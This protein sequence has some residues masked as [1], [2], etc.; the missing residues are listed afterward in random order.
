MTWTEDYDTALAIAREQGLPILVAIHHESQPVCRQL[1]KE[2]YRDREIV[3]LSRGLVMLLADASA[4]DGAGDDG[5]FGGVSAR[6]RQDIEMRVRQAILNEESPIAPQHVFLSSAGELILQKEYMLSV[7]ELER[8]MQQAIKIEA[9]SGGG[10]GADPASIQSALTRYREADNDALRA[11]VVRE[12][13]DAGSNAAVEA[14]LD[15]TQRQSRARTE[16][17]R[18]LA[19]A[20]GESEHADATPHLAKLLKHRTWQVREG[21]ARGL[22]TLADSGAMDLIRERLGRERQPMVKGRLLEAAATCGT[23]DPDTA[24]LILAHTRK[25]PTSVRIDAIVA[26]HHFHGDVRAT[27]RLLEILEDGPNENLRAAAAWSLA[28]FE[29]PG[30]AEAL[31]EAAEK[32]RRGRHAEVFASAARYHA[33]DPDAGDGFEDALGT[34]RQ[35]R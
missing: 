35:A 7:K 30:V 8:L 6:S 4:R 11:S 10:A 16:S 14:L 18:Q 26:L 23:E 21:A 15:S 13:L 28:W 24:Q 2:H 20:L 22:A 12:L 17:L 9:R 34:L 27:T 3:E 31:A 1:L 25:G 32:G 19:R 29:G 5:L 33:A